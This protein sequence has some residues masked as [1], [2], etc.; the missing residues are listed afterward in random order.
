MYL[1]K[2]FTKLKEKVNA[3]LNRR[4]GDKNII[5]INIVT[6]LCPSSSSFLDEDSLVAFENF[7]EARATG[8][9]YDVEN[10]AQTSVLPPK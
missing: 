1:F 6:L 2:T 4:S 9:S 5:M 7:N 8:Q 10:L 3:E